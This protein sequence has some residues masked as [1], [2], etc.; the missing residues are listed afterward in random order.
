MPPKSANKASKP[1]QTAAQKAAAAIARQTK[2]VENEKVKA[3]A[4]E[5]EQKKKSKDKEEQ[6]TIVKAIKRRAINLKSNFKKIP[7]D[8]KAESILEYM[9]NLKEKK[10]AG[11]QRPELPAKCNADLG[12]VKGVPWQTKKTLDLTNESHFKCA[13]AKWR[14]DHGFTPSQ[15]PIPGYDVKKSKK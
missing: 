2:K 15:Y 8:K 1:R 5:T 3:I 4:K 9:E 7:D 14:M 12:F 10:T 6:E 13:F 11:Y